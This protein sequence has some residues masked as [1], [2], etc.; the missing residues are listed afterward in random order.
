MIAT[1]I[2][3]IYTK[4]IQSSLA[5]SNYNEPDISMAPKIIYMMVC[6]VGIIAELLFVC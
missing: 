3:V 1:G 4:D 6:F 2:T 5:M